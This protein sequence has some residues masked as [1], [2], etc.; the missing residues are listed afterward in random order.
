M[1]V[2]MS[3]SQLAL[4][5]GLLI[6]MAVLVIGLLGF[7]DNVKKAKETPTVTA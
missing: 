4:G 2:L 1:D 6:V 5:V 7:G 3:K